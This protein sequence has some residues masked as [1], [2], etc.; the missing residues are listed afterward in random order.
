ML[1]TSL[2]QDLYKRFVRPDATDRDVLRVAR[3]AS[4]AGALLAIGVALSIAKD[5]VDALSIFYTLLGVSL[6]VPIVAGL[7]SRRAR[8]V[9]ALA[10]IAG[11]VLTLVAIQFGHRAPVFGLTPPMCGL[12]AAVLAFAVV[13]IGAR[14]RGQR[15]GAERQG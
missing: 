13:S 14:S 15:H 10:A 5:V 12:A 6:F 7:W 3:L 9:D 4:V 2:S 8:A 11:G 1:A